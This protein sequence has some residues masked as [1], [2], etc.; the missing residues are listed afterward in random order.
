MPRTSEGFE[1]VALRGLEARKEGV[2]A[3]VRQATRNGPMSSGRP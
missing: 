2:V 3:H 1:R